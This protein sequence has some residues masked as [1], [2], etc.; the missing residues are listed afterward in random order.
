MLI[1][2][3]VGLCLLK[4]RHGISVGSVGS[5]AGMEV[6]CGCGCEVGAE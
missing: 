6:W 2:G 5:V 1:A 3:G 4:T